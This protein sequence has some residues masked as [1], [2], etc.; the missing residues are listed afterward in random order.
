MENLEYLN[1]EFL[2][3][4]KIK[5]VKNSISAQL[6]KKFEKAKTTTQMVEDFVNTIK[7]EKGNLAN[8]QECFKALAKYCENQPYYKHLKWSIM[9]KIDIDMLEIP[10]SI[11]DIS[12]LFE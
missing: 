7:N 12:E 11:S 3:P 10:Q 6:L 1:L 9:R 2:S 5:K 8:I 4:V